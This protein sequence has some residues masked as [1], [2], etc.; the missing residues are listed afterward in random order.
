MLERSAFD[1]Q[2]NSGGRVLDPAGQLQ[3]PG[4]TE[5][6]GSKAHALDGA[7]APQSEPD[8]VIAAHSRS[9]VVTARE[10]R[11]AMITTR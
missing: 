11:R 4:E 10:T 1:L 6:E 9:R 5:D 8:T 3:R 2:Q 7:A